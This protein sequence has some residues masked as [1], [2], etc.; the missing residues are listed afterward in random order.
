M[1]LVEDNAVNQI[2]ASALPESMGAIIDIANNGEEAVMLAAAHAY[3]IILMDCQMPVMDGFTATRLIRAYENEQNLP[4]V[5]II[6]L[7]ANALQGDREKCIA[8]G[9][10]DYISKPVKQEV[11]YK[12]LAHWR[13]VI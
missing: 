8:A 4:H 11:I 2:V 9:M 6:A 10:D 13:Q 5:P 3:N 1:L 12:K 7:T